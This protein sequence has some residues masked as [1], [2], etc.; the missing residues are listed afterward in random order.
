MTNNSFIK[1]NIFVVASVAVSALILLPILISCF[2]ATFNSD[3]FSY[4][5]CTLKMPGTNILVQ[6]FNTMKHSWYEWQG[7][8]FSYLVSCIFNPVY[9]M[10]YLGLRLWMAA[11]VLLTVV[12][13]YAITIEACR[14]LGVD[15]KYGWLL[16][17]FTIVLGTIYRNYNQIYLWWVGSMVYLLPFAIMLIGMA[18]LLRAIRIRS[19]ACYVISAILLFAMTGG[20]LTITGFGCYLLLVVFIYNFI[21]DKKLNMALFAVCVV[22]LVGALLNAAAPGNFARHGGAD[23]VV[24]PMDAVIFTL[25]VIFTDITKYILKDRRIVLVMLMCYLWLVIVRPRMSVKN[26]ILSLISAVFL[27]FITAFPGTLGYS[28]E[29]IV[30]YPDRCYFVLDISIILFMLLLASVIWSAF[31]SCFS[32]ISFENRKLNIAVIPVFMLITIVACATKLPFPVSVAANLINGSVA[33]NS[34]ATVKFYEDVYTSDADDV[35]IEANNPGYI[36]GSLLLDVS[37]EPDY[38]ANQDIAEF[39]CK[40]TL[41][42]NGW[43]Q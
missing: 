6:S 1:K 16:S 15:T 5:V 30:D 29:G 12:G 32:R 36:D 8:W 31:H 13:I 39:F 18:F 34:A 28:G 9:N 38:W 35:I 11:I 40:N 33:K 41:T 21:K 10:N 23:T 42:V 2:Y 37:S 19:A 43:I 14:T 20:N 26:A 7:T 27:P 24:G 22:T 17:A 4:A 3:D 25:R